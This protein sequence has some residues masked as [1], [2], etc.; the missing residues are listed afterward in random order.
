MWV[1]NETAQT[2]GIEFEQFAE[3]H[4]SAT[5]GRGPKIIVSHIVNQD[6]TDNK[7]QTQAYGCLRHQ[8]ENT[9]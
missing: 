7:A 2:E 1:D 5:V 4:R 6:E 9:L 3:K 8:G